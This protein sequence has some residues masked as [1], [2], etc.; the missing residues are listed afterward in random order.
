MMTGLIRLLGACDNN[1]TI[2][3]DES[4]SD[5]ETD[6]RVQDWQTEDSEV[7]ESTGHCGDLTECGDDDGGVNP[8]GPWWYLM[9]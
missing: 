1:E 8:T 7:T 6:N 4:I 2:S 3:D 9:L 5:Q